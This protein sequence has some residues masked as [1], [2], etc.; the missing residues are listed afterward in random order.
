M[1]SY[2][3][4]IVS[5]LHTIPAKQLADDQKLDTFMFIDREEHYEIMYNLFKS[6]NIIAYDGGSLEESIIAEE[7]TLFLLN[8]NL[9]N[10][11][12]AK[13]LRLV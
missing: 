6:I 9:L 10:K 2:D 13:S 12:G 3:N 5:A 1:G 7:M 8:L 4:I 11:I